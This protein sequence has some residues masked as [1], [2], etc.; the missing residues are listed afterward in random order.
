MR[1]GVFLPN[2][3]G[4][5]AMATPALRSLRRMVDSSGSGPGQIF[6]VLRPYVSE[7]L[8]GANFLDQQILFDPRSS[9]PMLQ[10]G[11]VVEALRGAQLD[12]VV[13]FTNS[14]R[15]A[16]LA[17]RSGAKE[18]FGYDRNGRG[19]LLTT[20]LFEPRSGRKLAPLPTIDS[21][22]NLAYAAGG[23]W[24]TPKLYLA[25]TPADEAAADDVWWRLRLPHGDRVVVLNSGG[26]YGGAKHWPVEHFASLA[27]KIVEKLGLVVLVNCGPAERQIARDIVQQA[28]RSEVVSL[29][30][31]DVPLGLS[32]AII[33]RARLLVTTDSGPRYFGVAFGRPVVSLFGP[34]GI[35]ATRTHYDGERCLSLN[36]DCSPCMARTCPLSHHRCMRDL[37]VEQVFSSVQELLHQRVTLAA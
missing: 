33:R 23:P 20:R 8:A 3:I 26:A 22:L 29:A 12:R 7:T 9:D 15:T 14:W 6:G 11:G 28:K 18:R 36:L 2:W 21:Y 35:A 32:K 25:T 34:T 37:S 16:W 31:L 13:L 4:D 19:L 17:W 30:D 24:E 10:A 27:R 5:V 1:L